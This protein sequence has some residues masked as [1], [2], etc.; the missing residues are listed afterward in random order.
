MGRKSL[1]FLKVLSRSRAGYDM[2]TVSQGGMSMI[3]EVR[4]EPASEA[5]QGRKTM[6]SLRK[7]RASIEFLAEWG[8][9]RWYN[10]PMAMNLIRPP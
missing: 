7:G 9:F 3:R 2:A 10:F 8:H 5:I 1:P 4:T 6:R